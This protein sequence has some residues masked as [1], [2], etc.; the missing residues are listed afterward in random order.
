MI[1][2]IIPI[3]E[4]NHRNN[5]I[6]QKRPPIT[7]FLIYENRLFLGFTSINGILRANII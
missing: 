6:I 3:H 4:N 5:I 2:G 1:L 7:I